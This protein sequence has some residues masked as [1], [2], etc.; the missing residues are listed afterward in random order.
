[1]KEPRRYLNVTERDQCQVCMDDGW[2]SLKGRVRRLGYSYTRGSAPCRWCEQGTK[3]YNA[4]KNRPKEPMVES[5]YGIEDVD[6]YDPEPIFPTKAEAAAFLRSIMPNLS[7]D[8]D[9]PNRMAPTMTPFDGCDHDLQPDG[10]PQARPWNKDSIQW[11]RCRH[12]GM[13]HADTVKLEADHSQ[14]RR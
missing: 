12:C 1:M 13:E 6:G 10:P 8:H 4:A 7:L 11:Y 3:A 2:V 9:D 5:N 14:H